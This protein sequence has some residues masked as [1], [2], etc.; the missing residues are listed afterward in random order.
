M[1]REAARTSLLPGAHT[2]GRYTLRYRIAQ[3]GMAS[4]YLAQ[5][6]GSAGFDKWIAVKTIH[7]HIAESVRFV[8]MF[9][10][11]ARL[12]SKLEHPN[13]CSVLDFGEENG[14]WFIAM[15]YLHG[16]TFGVVARSGWGTE[17]PPPCAMCA[18]IVADAA[19]G[20]VEPD[21]DAAEGGVVAGSAPI[22]GFP[23]AGAAVVEHVQ[24]AG[25]ILTGQHVPGQVIAAIFH[26]GLKEVEQADDAGSHMAPACGCDAFHQTFHDP[27]TEF[28]RDEIE[29]E[30]ESLAGLGL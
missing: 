15:E 3:G 29:G 17:L 2:L 23:D 10:D 26:E 5:L 13:L 14:T 19:R 20:L 8:N 24:P 28:F 27:G 22:P 6:A 9:L 16:E 7:P 11:E 18:R 30:G 1:A 12:A 21:T 25:E 4:V